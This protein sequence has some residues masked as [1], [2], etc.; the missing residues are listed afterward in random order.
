MEI[1]IDLDHNKQL[2]SH[3][4][5]A[6]PSWTTRYGD[7]DSIVGTCYLSTMRDGLNTSCRTRWVSWGWEDYLGA[8]SAHAARHGVRGP[9]TLPQIHI[10]HLDAL[11]DEQVAED[12]AEILAD[13][14]W[15][16]VGEMPS[17]HHGTRLDRVLPVRA[18]VHASRSWVHVPREGV[19]PGEVP[20]MPVTR[21]RVLQVLQEADGW[22]DRGEV[23][24]RM[25]CRMG[26]LSALMP[27]MADEGALHAAMRGGRMRYTHLSHEGDA[28]TV[29]GQTRTRARESVPGSQR[30]EALM[31][32]SDRWRTVRSIQDALGVTNS[33]V[34]STLRRMVNRGDALVDKRLSR[35]VYYAP[36]S[37]AEVPPVPTDIDEADSPTM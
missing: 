2:D 30:V 7:A 35:A 28:P 29:P 16:H 24:R 36:L 26:P 37:G 18:V 27:V 9:V 1:N 33:V 3:I 32:D 4:A 5:G 22:V 13:G 19:E 31:V 14:L 20:D 12:V 11:E 34:T 23:A 21:D 25:S 17:T 6:D 8:V 10:S 15:H